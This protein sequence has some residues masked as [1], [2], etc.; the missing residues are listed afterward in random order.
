MPSSGI[1][2]SR[3][4]TAFIDQDS[5]VCLLLQAVYGLK[6]SSFLWHQELKQ[7]LIRLAFQPSPDDPSV[8]IHHPADEYSHFIIIYVDDGLIMAKDRDTAQD[9]KHKLRAA[10]DLKNL[11]PPSKFLDSHLH[12]HDGFIAMSQQAYV[13]KILMQSGMQFSKRL[14]IPMPSTY[15]AIHDDTSLLSD[16][17][18]SDYVHTIGQFNW[19]SPKT[20]PDITQAPPTKVV[21][22][23]NEGLR[24]IVEYFTL[25]SSSSTWN[26]P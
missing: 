9:I 20:R 19:P 15:R 21:T 11:G 16:D 10:F 5:L 8:F 18:K 12:S 26:P 22:V 14:P 6:Q 13:N 1:M 23:Y 2:Q 17:R 25:P 24:R 7:L 4:P 3:Q